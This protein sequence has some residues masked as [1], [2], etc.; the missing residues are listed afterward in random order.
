MK[1]LIILFI[2]L[3]FFTFAQQV[4]IKGKI[5]D[6]ET[7][8][9]LVNAN[10]FISSK[11]GVGTFSDLNG[12]FNLAADVKDSDTLSASFIGYET[13]KISI[14][15]MLKIP[16]VLNT[17]GTAFYTFYLKKKAIPSQTILVEA[18]IGKR[19]ITPLAFD[20]LNAAEIEKTYSLY[21]IPKYLSELTINYI[22]F[23]KWKWH[24]I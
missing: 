3:N 8:S 19:G 23:R 20:Q 6:A 14:E 2:T 13:S 15:Q 4:T 21:D 10:I 11:L 7:N 18:T 16:G 9:P 1:I 12:E 22:L 24:R 5:V 17:D